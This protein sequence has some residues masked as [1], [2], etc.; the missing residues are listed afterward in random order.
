MIKYRSSKTRSRNGMYGNSTELSGNIGMIAT[1]P[2]N[3]PNPTADGSGLAHSIQQLTNHAVGEQP[4][5]PTQDQ[6]AVLGR[7][8]PT[9]AKISETTSLGAC[10]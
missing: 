3:H 4:A 8:E 6:L 10:E 7:Y 1:R 5:V 2:A 9:A